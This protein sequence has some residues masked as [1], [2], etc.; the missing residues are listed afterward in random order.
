MILGVRTPPRGWFKDDSE[1]MQGHL[2]RGYRALTTG[3]TF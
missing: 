3:Q 1:I 2:S